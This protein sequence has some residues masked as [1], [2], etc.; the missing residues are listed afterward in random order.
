MRFPRCFMWGIITA[1]LM[2]TLTVIS[3]CTPLN[4]YELPDQRLWTFSVMFDDTDAKS[5]YALSY[6]CILEGA[7]LVGGSLGAGGRTLVHCEWG[8]SQSCA[9]CAAYAVLYRHWTA[10]KAIEYI[11]EQNLKGR[12]Y[13][14]QR[15]LQN[16]AFTTII[17]QAE[18][19]RDKILHEPELWKESSKASSKVIARRNA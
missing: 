5:E 2:A 18:A 14:H 4:R 6:D 11:T 8:Q 19:N 16:K 1:L 7:A 17:R 13:W 9:I 15:P 3:C 10:E 12:G